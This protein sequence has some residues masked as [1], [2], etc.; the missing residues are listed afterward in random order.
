VGLGVVYGDMT[1]RVERDDSEA[2]GGRWYDTECAAE[3]TLLII[4]NVMLQG[5]A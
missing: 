5:R 2:G 1:E 4:W 3:W